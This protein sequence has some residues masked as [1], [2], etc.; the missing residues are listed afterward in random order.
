MNAKADSEVEYLSDGITESMIHSLSRLPKLRVMARSTV[1]AYR[2]KEVDPRKVGGD[3]NVDAI[4]TGN[5][6][7]RSM[8]LIIHAELVRVSDGTLVWSD[9]YNRKLSDI[10]MDKILAHIPN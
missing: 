10:L 4:L 6:T 2:G 5:M 8:A 1:F 3:L 9:E 7:Q